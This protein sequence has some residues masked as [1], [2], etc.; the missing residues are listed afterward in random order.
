MLG[1]SSMREG[2]PSLPPRVTC[3]QILFGQRDQRFLAARAGQL[4][5]YFGALL[6][7]IPYVDQ[8]EALHEFLCSPDVA[9]MGYEA[10]LDLAEAVGDAPTSD[11]PVTRS[12]IEALPLR[13]QGAQPSASAASAASWCPICQEELE[14]DGDIRV[15]PCGHEYHFGCIS[16]WVQLKNR[17]CVC[18]GMAVIPSP[19]AQS[20]DK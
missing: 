10:L 14:A 11:P 3:R 15:L 1:V 6:R 12:E 19:S 5:A 13:G 4:Q 8:C 9:S 16:Q 18:Q 17:C 20:V 2:L 7:H